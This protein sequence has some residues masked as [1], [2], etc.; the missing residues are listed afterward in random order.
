MKDRGPS[1]FT[2]L[3]QISANST[4]MKSLQE[5]GITTTIP[6]SLIR[7]RANEEAKRNTIPFQVTDRSAFLNL[8]KDSAAPESWQLVSAEIPLGVG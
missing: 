4:A 2:N 3:Y 5:N 1:R 6:A 7:Q 8:E